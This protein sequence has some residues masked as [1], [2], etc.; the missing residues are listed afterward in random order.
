MLIAWKGHFLTHMPHPLQSNSE[1][2]ALFLSIFMASTLLRTMG[3]KLTQTLSHFF[4]LHLS[5]S[6]TATRVMA[7]SK[8]QV[9]W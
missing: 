1:I 6:S 7:N 4:T 2:T 3:Q 8:Y 5:M 9:N